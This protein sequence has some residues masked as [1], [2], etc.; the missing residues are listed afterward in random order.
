MV[1]LDNIQVYSDNKCN[2]NFTVT[3]KCLTSNNKDVY[4]NH[5]HFSNNHL[6][7]AYKANNLK[8]LHQNI[9]GISHKIDEFLISFSLT[10][11]H[12]LSLTEHH[13]RTEEINYI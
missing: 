9:W 10:T 13:L 2:D 3:P 4:R 11:P 7:N 8:I 12:V 1:N 5:T 6:L